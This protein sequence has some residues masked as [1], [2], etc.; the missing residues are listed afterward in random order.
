MTI[1][2]RFSTPLMATCFAF[3]L[4]ACNNSADTASATA[5]TT[6]MDST[7][8]DTAKAAPVVA[9]AP[10]L[11][12]PFDI[13][14]AK[15]TL[16]DYA[17]WKPGFDANDS[18]RKAAGLE[19]LVI[20]QVQDKPNNIEVVLKADD[21]KKAKDFFSSPK[22]KEVMAKAGVIGKSE[23]SYFHVIRFNA[24][25][26][27]KQ[28]VEVTH[29]VKNFDAWEKVYDAEGTDKRKSEGMVDVVLARGMGAD[30]NNV[31]II[32]DITDMAK[33]KAAIA[34]PEKKKTMMNAGVM[35][36]PRIVFYKDA[37]K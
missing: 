27:E 34:S 6:K 20:A 33:A 5:D 3:T 12:A 26:K 22:L 13:A 37:E 17:A 1:L 7:K 31:Q 8:A 14:E 2:K 4:A 29:K 16:K 35:G 18:M 36:V 23:F 25:S 10:A 11:A 19:K 28:W 15:Q 30:S 9:A 32:F 21:V 24:A